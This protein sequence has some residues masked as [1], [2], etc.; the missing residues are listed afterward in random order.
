VTRPHPLELVVPAGLAAAVASSARG[1]AQGAAVAGE[2][3]IEVARGRDG[4]SR[5][6]RAYATSPLRLLTPVNHGRA[7][8][9]YASSYGGGLVDGDCV[10]LEAVVGRG[11]AAYIST[12]ASTKVY[13]SFRG[14]EAR[15]RAQ[16]ASGA[17]LVVA[18][19]PVVCFAGSRYR[20]QQ[21][22]AVAPD[23]GL[24]LVDWITSGRRASGERW[25]FDEYVAR[26]ELVVGGRRALCETLTLRAAH[27]DLPSRLDR[28]DVLALVVLAGGLLDAHA[29]AIMKRVERTPV[30]RKA[31]LAMSA[32]PLR[33]G[34]CVV[35]I[36]GPSMEETGAVIAR[37]LGFVPDLL[38]DDPWSRKW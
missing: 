11:S 7:A 18:P 21:T 13:R 27:G 10:S 17:L 28:F 1:V 8:W 15:V 6:V 22:F 19:D 30:S 29:R 23:G 33:T 12:Q 34:G 25:Q 38:G 4:R 3:L 24:A 16:V 36:A 14:T 37:V 35:R 26:T 31:R 20:Q 5:V 32:A 9:I 2:G